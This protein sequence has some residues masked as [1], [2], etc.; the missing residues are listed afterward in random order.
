MSWSIETKIEEDTLVIT[1][2]GEADK[3]E[4]LALRERVRS[5]LEKASLRHVLLDLRRAVLHASMLD[6]FEVARSNP[7]AIP[8]NVKYAVVFSPETLSIQNVE[9]G[10]N[11][12]RNRGADLRAFTDISEARN[13]L[14]GEP[15]TEVEV[16]Q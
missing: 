8:S 13:W 10:E 7:N 5:I 11:V 16:A 15:N 1:L 2:V 14:T 4:Y 9:L 12:A 6:V 3:T